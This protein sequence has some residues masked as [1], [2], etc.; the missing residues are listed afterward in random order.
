LARLDKEI[1]RISKELPR[2]EGKLNNPSFV[3]KAP[4]EVIDKEKA[5]LADLQSMLNNLE[6]QQRKIQ[7]L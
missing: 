7:S 4:P 2:I 5:K 3:D 1:Q 6:Q